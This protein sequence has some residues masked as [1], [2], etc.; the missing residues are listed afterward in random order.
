L[1]GS[2]CLALENEDTLL[3]LLIDLDLNRSEFFKSLEVSFLSMQSLALFLAEV[4]FDDLCEEI[5][6]KV[7]SRL[8]Q[9]SL[10][11]LRKRR[12]PDR[13]SGKSVILSHIPRFLEDLHGKDW[14]LL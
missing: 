8:K 10:A 2:D 4:S 11:D 12:H 1:L 14:T 9:D 6:L 13:L 5:W 7:I 3:K